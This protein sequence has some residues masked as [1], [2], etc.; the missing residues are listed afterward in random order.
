MTTVKFG[1][2]QPVMFMDAIGEIRPAVPAL[3]RGARELN[4]KIS[5]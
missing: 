5:T 3:A 2:R 4:F 1:I